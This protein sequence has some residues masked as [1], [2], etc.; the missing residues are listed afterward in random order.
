MNQKYYRNSEKATVSVNLLSDPAAIIDEKGNFLTVNGALEEVTGLSRKE[1]IG[2]PFLK[3]NIFTAE[4]KVVLLENLKKRL[5]GA[6]V[7]PYE[8]VFTDKLGEKRCVEVKGKKVSYAGQTADIVLFHDINLRKENAKQLKKCSEQM[9]V[10]VKE[11][12]KEVKDREEKYRNIFENAQDMI[13][14]FD[15]KGNITSINSAALEYG[16]IK[17]E[18]IGKNMLVF[19]PKKYWPILLRDLAELSRGKLAR[20][21]VEIITP[22]GN[23]IVEY[24][25]TPVR[26]VG[27][28]VGFQ[29]IL[30][31]ITERCRAEEEIATKAKL[32]DAATDAIRL[33]DFEGNILYVNESTCRLS[34]YGKD[35]LLK[36]RIQDLSSPEQAKLIESRIK[37]LREKGEVA[38]EAT[39]V[40]KDKST[41]PIEVHARVIELGGKKLSL[42]VVRDITE[43]KKAEEALRK[44][45]EEYRSL[46]SNM[47]DGFAYCRMIFDEAGKPVD[48]VYLQINDAFERITGL[49]RDEIV[50]KK[51]SAAI[52]GIKEANPKLFEIYGRVA[53]T[54]KEERFE[55]FFKPLEMWLS[56]G[57]YSPEKGYFIAVFENITERKKADLEIKQKNEAL[58]SVTESIDSGLAV[59]SKDYRVVWANKYL[60]DLGVA[61]NKKCYQ[62]FNS[63]ET[64]CPDC[65]VK[66]VFEQNVSLDVHEF[67]TVNSKGETV[68][69]ELRVTPLKDKNGNVTAALEL[70]VPI[71]ER[72]KAE[73][74]I[75]WLASFPMLNPSPVLEVSFEGNIS[76]LNSAAESIFPDL[77]KV[78]LSHP[79]LSGWN[80]VLATFINKKNRTF[81][82]NIKI[83]DAW[84]HQ[85]FNLL[86]ETQQVRI[87]VINITEIKQAEEALQ[88][89]E[90]KFRMYVENSPVAVF[91]A[92]SEGKYEYVNE[93]ASK[94]LGYSIKE[95]TDMNVSQIAFNDNK[96]APLNSF[97]SLQENG[98]ILV[99]KW[100]KKKD[101]Q[102]VN[103]S[104]NVVK[105][106]SG[107][108]I[109]FCENITDRKILEAKVD[110][111]SK[112]LKSM[113][114]LRT[115]QLKDANERLVRSERL[116][117]IGE[118]A[119]MVGHDLRN[120][121]TGI[122]NA[123]YFLKKKG[124]T[125]SEAQAKEMLEIIDK[126]IDHSN[127][128]INDL[129]DYSRELRLELTESEPCA[130]LNEAMRMIQVPDRIQIVN[131][132]L[133]ESS[134]RVD[135]DKMMRV[136]INLIKNAVDAM[137]EKGRL[138]IRS[139]QI[140]GKVEI[141]FADTGTG[142]PEEVLPKIFSPL[143]T[144]KAQG[145][146]FGLAICK[147]IIE[148]H[149]GT[150][151]VK[152]AVN[153]GTTF[154]I[155]LPIKPKLEVKKH[156]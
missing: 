82:R 37:D 58:E 29:T 56:V 85:Q 145:M 44:S 134:V 97:A 27:K 14:V 67:K 66:K 92:D 84:F 138:E 131:H 4:T 156:G 62:T 57:V 153:K 126:S 69:I 80:D 63:S 38:F 125:I 34:G 90:T 119:G 24:K 151:T 111:Y 71:T 5:Q 19:V 12:V 21:E 91:V 88:E 99:E 109:A 32:L 112:H 30:R 124:A 33:Y 73:E 140:G 121:L 148:A 6:P 54:G 100:L 9:E 48:F 115:A 133:G 93:A 103:V 2:N 117:A 68:W 46:F 154:A 137:P 104:L 114:E 76:Y 105:L 52:P 94:L 1:L 139:R 70:A 10:L 130:L 75:A 142:I 144:T 128:I 106:P 31:D 127:N 118:L 101:G 26:Q 87:Y 81:G 79:I 16:F 51:V 3:L 17:D 59:I 123:A 64:V 141:A 18:V 98:K 41:V 132:V 55:I 43:H 25:S 50:G 15:L 8:I 86:Q 77:K 22:K 7:E 96:S 152:T 108:L 72:K 136:F 110:N 78:G 147:R 42:S 120:P 35:E 95:L 107:K 60:M 74:K 155:T 53:L 113:V 122:K 39:N 47:I 23:I 28:V 40:R 20:A 135:A 61:P 129:L 150:I 149:G 143:F 83:N 49:K 102:A 116:A 146:G 45:E 36:M 11:K 89:S 65:G 13:I